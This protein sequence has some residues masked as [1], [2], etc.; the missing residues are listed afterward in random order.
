MDKVRVVYILSNAM[1][2]GG[3]E[4][5]IMN[6]YRH[7][8]HDKIQMDFIYQ[9]DIDGVYD[10][11]LLE[12]GSVIHHVPYKAQHPIKF[13]REVKRILKKGNYQVIHSQMDAMGCWPLAIAKSVG[14]PMRIAHS[15]NTKHQTNNP[16]KLMLNDIAK[17]LL[18]KYATD[19]YACGYDAG[20]F[21][22]GNT[23][24]KQNKIQIIHN[25]IELDKYAYSD[26]K[27]AKMREEFRLKN[28]IVIGHVG[29][30]REQ[31]NHK[32]II[33]IFT[34]IAK[35][36]SNVKLML[37]GDGPLKSD[38]QTMVEKNNIRDKVI[39][40]G[41]RDDVSDILNVFDVFLFPSLFEG[42]PVVAVE[43]QANGLP[44][45][46]SDVISDETIITDNVIK[47]KL[48]ADAC[49]WKD[50]IYNALKSCRK[51]E[52]DKLIKAGYDIVTEAIKLEERYVKSQKN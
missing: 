8:N 17:L 24:T 33:E 3:I 36:D 14:V 21:M 10:K 40:A 31:K 45:V 37:V 4:A 41:S 11:E 39:F 27:R 50:A 44:M 6:Y 49:V 38:I 7:I 28:E 47:E 13:S 22:F 42:L 29:Q 5:F 15:H 12:N 48:E 20:V 18:R 51:D 16:I 30:F 1:F 32:K 23:L 9:G 43:A 26:L 46:I 25:A 2:R 52:R 19:Y 35:A 34:E